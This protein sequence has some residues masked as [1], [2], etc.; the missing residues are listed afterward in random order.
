[1]FVSEKGILSFL[2]ELASVD[3]ALPLLGSGRTW[4]DA[5]T[6][7]AIAEHIGSYLL[8]I[9]FQPGDLA[10]YRPERNVPSAL[11]ILG[12][13]SAGVTAVLADPGQPLEETLSGTETPVPIRA[14]IE[15]TGQSRFK[16]F[17]FGASVCRTEVFD[18][19]HAEQLVMT[20]NLR[21]DGI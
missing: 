16:I 1:M 15:Y 17:W 4:L 9:G 20:N 14:Q 8:R 2:E 18:L 11:M 19:Q 13:R 3:P 10:A 7:L 6:V 21:V 12:L 5:R